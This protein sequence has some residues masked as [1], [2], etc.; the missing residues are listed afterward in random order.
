MLGF[1][2]LNTDLDEYLGCRRYMNWGMTILFMDKWMKLLFG[3]MR[4]ELETI[5]FHNQ[6]MAY[7]VETTDNRAAVIRH[8]LP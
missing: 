5:F 2:E 1:M 6:F 3:K 7:E 4:T 8:D